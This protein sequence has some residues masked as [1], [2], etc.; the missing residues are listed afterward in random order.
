MFAPFRYKFHRHWVTPAWNVVRPSIW[1]PMSNVEQSLLDIPE[2][3]NIAPHVHVHRDSPF[4]KMQD[5]QSHDFFS[6]LPP[7]HPVNQ[8]KGNEGMDA[9]SEPDA[10]NESTDKKL[11][12]ADKK[13]VVVPTYNFH[14]AKSTTMSTGASGKREADEKS[15]SAAEES[16][17]KETRKD[18]TYQTYSYSSSSVEQDG[19]RVQS[20]RRR[21]EDSTGRIK[22]LHERRIGDTFLLDVWNK[23]SNE[24]EGEHKKVLN[25]SDEDASA[26]ETLWKETPFGRA[27]KHWLEQ[28][29]ELC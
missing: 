22:A 27:E 1:F 4:L 13:N 18:P 6:D 24:E 19:Q 8:L 26:F 12:E 11:Q 7:F 5:E 29:D 20:M 21:Y 15:T 25:T 23:K 28:V 2:V 16:H 10:A 9:T 14:P 17:E 3:V